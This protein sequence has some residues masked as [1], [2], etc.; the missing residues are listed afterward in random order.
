MSG[1]IPV[2]AVTYGILIAPF[3]ILSIFN[4][5]CFGKI[6]GVTN[7]DIIFLENRE[8]SIKDIVKIIYHPRVMSREKINFSYAT[9][10]VRSKENEHE[11]FD[12]IHFPIYGLRTIKK[13]NKDIKLSCDKYIW[14]LIWCPTV[15]F[16]ILGFLLG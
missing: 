11:S 5:F 15:V 8:I 7:E 10:I 6:L 14:F 1:A 9:F 4:R 3:V 2:I 13:Y 16:A 12:L